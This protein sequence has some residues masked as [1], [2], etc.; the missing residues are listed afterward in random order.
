VTEPGNLS[1]CMVEGDLESL[2]RARRLRQRSLAASIALQ[3]VGVTAMLIWPLIAA[4]GALPPP[5]ILTPLP[6]YH[7]GGAQTLHRHVRTTERQF[8][9]VLTSRLV[10]RPES[11]R[12]HEAAGETAPGAGPPEPNDLGLGTDSGPGGLFI[13]GGSENGIRVPAPR[14]P[15]AARPIHESEGVMAGALI[16]RVDPVYPAIART[17]HLSG[18]VRLRAIIA[19][20]GSVQSLEVLSGS[21][22]L[23]RAAVA[24]VRQWQYRPTRLDG[25]PVEVE[26]LITVNFVLSE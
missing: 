9:Q 11:R 21:P 2:A 17:I 12:A 13:P 7:G 15:A 22:I 14:E 10:F 16:H 19:T 24:A 8:Q 1:Q 18:T 25:M 5:Y 3:A 20:D 26:T 4:P 6:P 23:A